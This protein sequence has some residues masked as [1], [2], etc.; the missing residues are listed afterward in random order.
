MQT[1]LD[2]SSAAA[3]MLVAFWT[4]SDFCTISDCRNSFNNYLKTHEHAKISLI[5][6]I[7]SSSEEALKTSYIYRYMFPFYVV[8]YA[9]TE[10]MS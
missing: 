10:F 2:Y 5:Q 7:Q 4:G 3:I 6:Q 1:E 8:Q 9:N